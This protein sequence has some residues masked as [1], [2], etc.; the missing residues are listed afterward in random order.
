MSSAT[1]SGDLPDIDAPPLK[2]KIAA[3]LAADVAGYS[4]LVAEDEERTLRALADAR[5]VFDRLVGR[6]GGRI[7]NT[8]GD[9]VMCDFDS[10]V[11]AVRAAVR[12]QEALAEG[13]RDRPTAQRLDFRIGITIGDVVERG[14]DL[15]GDG[16]NIAARLESIAPPGGI[17]I[18]RSV[19]EAVANKVDAPFRD[20]GPQRAKNLPQPIH[21]FVYSPPGSL[22]ATGHDLVADDASP[23]RGRLKGT[24]RSGSRRAGRLLR[25]AAILVAVSIG[26]PGL[27]ALRHRAAGWFET[28]DTAQ[29]TTA[30]TPG[31]SASSAPPATPPRPSAPATPA[32]QEPT[33]PAR[34]ATGRTTAREP[35]AAPERSQTFAGLAGEDVLPE[36]KDLA[37][38]YHN[39]RLLEA[40]GDRQGALK[41]YAMLAPLAGEA[42][43]PL[44]RYASLLRRVSGPE[45]AH[46]TIE[47]LAGTAP[48]KSERLVLTMGVEGADRLAKLD[49]L[50]AEQPDYAPAAYFHALAL[51]EKRR[52][53]PT[54]TERRLAFSALD[55]FL[56]AA[57]SGSLAALFIDKSVL[58]GWLD[59]ARMRRGEIETFFASTPT[60]PSASFVRAEGGWTADV[61]LPEPASAVTVRIGESGAPMPARMVPG[62]S[63]N[64]ATLFLPGATDRT[65]LY[66]T[67]RD[68]ARRDAG[69][70]PILF[71]PGTAAIAAGRDTLER[72][73]DTWVSFRPDLPNLVS[74][75]QLA[76]NRCAV[77]SALIGFG[78][79]PPKRP[80]PVP[81]CGAQPDTRT[82]MELPP[83]TDAVQVQL[84]YADGTETQARSFR[85]P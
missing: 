66:V 21:A 52:N 40:R 16:V 58:D 84:T 14:D 83:G 80:I 12:I 5:A 44:V 79:E 62:A 28:T 57:E 36:P 72:Y 37:S 35:A 24:D 7:F 8:A 59:T 25:I 85:R 39:A 64:Q 19:H 69:P 10:A 18:S 49:A 42:I 70:F 3:I 26:V 45:T 68:L 4:R 6:G 75:A 46:R 1:P 29:T 73:P 63:Q 56:D 31:Q 38:L 41:A 78:D 53:G 76:A 13:N 81:A 60:R 30:P 47:A 9:S 74:F 43:D 15:L 32:R 2:R 20:L 71:D 23:A 55:R 61:A 54:L 34:S 17:C 50:L 65:T 82:F 48:T 33:P 67:Y 51:T 27:N 11:E 77:R 22:Q